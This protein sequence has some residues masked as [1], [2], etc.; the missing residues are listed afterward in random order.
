[1]KYGGYIKRLQD[2]NLL[3]GK[4][5]LLDMGCGDG[6]DS[7]IFKMMG[8][9]VDGVDRRDY[10]IPEINFTQTDIRD[11]PIQKDKYSV[12]FCINTLPFIK[13]KSQVKDVLIKM[14]EGLATGG[15]MYFTL[16][17][18][19]DAWADDPTMSFYSFEEADTIA[20]SLPGINIIE[21]VNVEG[22][23]RTMKGEPKHF[24]IHHFIGVKD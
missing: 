4:G 9:E 12:I 17:G 10:T 18:Y 19:K 24:E 15:V 13:D 16:F 1:M 6:Y 5:N 2:L 21:N 23:G 3:T 11:F 22:E 8:Y 14:S 7:L 20:H